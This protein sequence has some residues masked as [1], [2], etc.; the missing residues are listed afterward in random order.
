MSSFRPP[1]KTQKA[2]GRNDAEQTTDIYEKRERSELHTEK[3]SRS[4]RPKAWREAAPA[5]CPSP[6]HSP[7]RSPSVKSPPCSSAS[8]SRRC[9]SSES[10]ST[11]P[12]CSSTSNRIDR[13]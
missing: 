6:S 12:S 1:Q 11:S 10:A 9:S 13:T 8:S 2:G 5:P 3:C 7:F 4:D